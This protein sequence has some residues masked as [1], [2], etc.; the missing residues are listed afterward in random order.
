MAW[1]LLRDIGGITIVVAILLN[2]GDDITIDSM[3]PF[4]LLSLHQSMITLRGMGVSVRVVSLE[5]A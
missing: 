1:Y 2:D 4:S 5:R 3:F